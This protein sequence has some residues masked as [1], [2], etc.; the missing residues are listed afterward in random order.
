MTSWISCFS[1]E[2]GF[3]VR[4]VQ[5]ISVR[6]Q[7]GNGFCQLKGCTGTRYFAKYQKLAEQISREEEEAARAEAAADEA[8]AA[9]LF[10]Q[11]G[12]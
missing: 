1:G 11:V 12:V 7:I 3:A 5:R 6:L 8:V 2:P 9:E 10:P 4:A